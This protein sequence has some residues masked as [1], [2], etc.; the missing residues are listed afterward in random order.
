MPQPESSLPMSS[1]SDTGNPEM[2][3]ADVELSE[4]LAMLAAGRSS[5]EIK[6]TMDGDK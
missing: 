4:L 6:T 3:D 5:A 2:E 1:A